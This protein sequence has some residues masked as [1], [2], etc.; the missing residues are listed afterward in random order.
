MAHGLYLVKLTAGSI[1]FIMLIS[2]LNLKV[3]VELF[4]R[5]KK[6]KTYYVTNIV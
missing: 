5:K 2:F 3:K 4:I 6:Q 1:I